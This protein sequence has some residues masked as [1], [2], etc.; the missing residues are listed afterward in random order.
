MYKQ[1]ASQKL[2]SHLRTDSS[3]MGTSFLKQSF[4]Q[5]NTSSHQHPTTKKEAFAGILAAT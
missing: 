3:G 4:Q 5:S 2:T 1:V